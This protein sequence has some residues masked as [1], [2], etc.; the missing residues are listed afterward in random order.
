MSKSVKLQIKRDEAGDITV[1]LDGMELETVE[2]IQLHVMPNENQTFI[3][4]SLDVPELE[5]EASVQD[6]QLTTGAYQRCKLCGKWVIPSIA[7]NLEEKTVEAQY[8]C[9]DCDKKWS[10]KIQDWNEGIT[11]TKPITNMEG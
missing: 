2:Q 3:R 7:K 10:L 6:I 5:V 4:L 11:E 8:H 1:F 9:V